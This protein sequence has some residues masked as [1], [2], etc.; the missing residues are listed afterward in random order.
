[1]AN[2]LAELV[3]R[4]SADVGSLQ[5]DFGRAL[6]DARK[7][8][9]AMKSALGVGLSVGGF[10][11]FIKGVVDAADRLNDLRTRTGLTGQE[12]LV[13]E[14]AAV[15]SGVGIDIVGATASRMAKRMEDA[16]KGTGDAANAFAAMGIKVTRTDGSLKSMLELFK[17]SGDKFKTWEDGA[18]KAAIATGA[19]G[20]G[21]DALIPL[22]E[23]LADTEARFKRLG[24]T[25][26]EDFIT[27]ADEFN[28]TVEDMKSVQMALGR[29]IATAL[30]PYMKQTVE[31]L[32][33]FQ[34]N[35]ELARLAVSAIIIPLKVMATG[36][37]ASGTAIA[38]S[39]RMLVGFFTAA[40]RAKKLDF[41]GALDELKLA[42]QESLQWFDRGAGIVAAFWKENEAGAKKAETAT[43]RG[44]APAMPDLA[45]AKKAAEALEK[46][47]DARAKIAL[48]ADKD[49][50]DKRVSL[51]ERMY[52]ENLVSERDYWT[53]RLAIQKDGLDSEFRT[54]DEQI[55]RQTA[56]RNKTGAGSK[57]RHDA[58]RELEETIAKRKKLE[59]DAAQA[60]II[61]GYDAAVAMRKYQ[62]S[63]TGVNIELEELRGNTEK[64]L[65]LRQEMSNRDLRQ[66]FMT[67]GNQQGLKDLNELERLQRAGA[68]FNDIR[69][70][71]EA[72]GSR[73][74]I[75]EQRIQNTL[76][77]G[78]ISEMESLRRTGDA[79]KAAAEQLEGL[80]RNLEE[81]ARASENPKLILQAEQARASLERLRS[82]SNLLADKFNSIGESA[83]ADFLTD[84][85]T[86][87]KTLKESI[88]DLGNTFVREVNR[89][90]AQDFAKRV[91]GGAT[92]TGGFGDFM[93]KLFSGG[94]SGGLGGLL[95]GGS[96][97]AAPVYDA[98]PTMVGYA[99]G[100]DFVPRT[101]PAVLHVGEKVVKASEN[102]R[103]REGGD[104]IIHFHHTGQMGSR[105]SQ[106]QTA[107]AIEIGLRRGRRIA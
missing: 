48:E 81:V 55:A 98:I 24:I 93:A 82:E 54:L 40:D 64:A 35:Q 83:L 47:L 2:T 50:T 25:I 105:R 9:G 65:Q 7:F 67:E 51:L 12:L 70:E 69:E 44:R 73:L 14:G 37:V 75:Q 11:I 100:T 1:M 21:G 5:R 18:D 6:G 52:Q 20:K 19:F 17:E 26:D 92:G 29:A 79:R 94:G 39:S 76:R 49:I 72:V 86:G 4:M 71:Q 31:V 60:A 87:T 85:M 66:K 30:L 107:Q 28:D 58:D 68:K 63:I 46:L 13:L 36:F 16:K 27:Q 103:G 56:A 45:E 96:Q 43:R 53:R 89:M 22:M 102:R 23:S 101:G 90:V 88:M 77:T 104:T 15:R 84:M 80:V 91:F 61:G 38:M 10:T 95:G 99:D 32:I 74:E 62:D 33:E 8:G 34:R 42:T 78:A 97:A 57:E 3:V 106:E 41:S 59:R